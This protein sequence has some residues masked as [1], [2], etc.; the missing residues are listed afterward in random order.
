MFHFE[1]RA[2][3]RKFKNVIASCNAT[4]KIDPNKMD[5]IVKSKAK[6]CF[7]NKKNF[8]LT[9]KKLKILGLKVKKKEKYKS[10]Y[11]S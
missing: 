1:S 6:K 8:K 5:I 4:T 10:S 9:L 2:G 3:G 7:L 11:P